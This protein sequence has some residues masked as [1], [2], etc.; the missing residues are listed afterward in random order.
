[1][2]N[3][4]SNELKNFIREELASG[5][6]VDESDLCSHALE[7]YRDVKRKHEELGQAIQVGLDDEKAGR[8]KS[9][10]P[11]EVIQR[12]YERVANRKSEN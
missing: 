4:E 3:I 12:G 2:I 10:N 6:F 9:L 11:D 7:V 5:R 8:V 1:M